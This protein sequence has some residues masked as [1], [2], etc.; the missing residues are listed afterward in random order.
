MAR[1]IMVP[2]DEW[3]FSEARET[4]YADG[5]GRS[6]HAAEVG[7]DVTFDYRPKGG[8]RVFASNEWT[9]WA[10]AADLAARGVKA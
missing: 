5:N 6:F 2:A 10:I 9:A 4:R 7:V 3:T 8:Y 1:T